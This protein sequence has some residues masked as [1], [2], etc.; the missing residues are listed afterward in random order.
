MMSLITFAMYLNQLQTCVNWN[1][2]TVPYTPPRYCFTCT[3]SAV[4]PAPSPVRN[5]T[6][7]SYSIDGNQITLD[8]DWTPPSMPN[9]ELA[10]YN[11]CIGGQPLAPSD[12]RMGTGEGYACSSIPHQES[13]RYYYYV[14]R[15]CLIHARMHGDNNY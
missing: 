15:G 6:V 9:G 7:T 10:P 13:V 14:Y 3:E 5:F 8:M 2:S 11:I 1:T 4:S 12:N